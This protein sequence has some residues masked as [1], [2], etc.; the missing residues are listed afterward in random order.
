MRPAPLALL[1]AAAASVAQLALAPSLA[2]VRPQP[3]GGDPR[4]QIAN[5]DPDEVIS[6]RIASGF[7]LTIQL[8]T[9]ERV[10][11]ISVGDGSG[12][13]VQATKRGDTVFV[14]ST[15]SAG[16][17]NLTILTDSRRYLFTLHPVSGEDASAPLVL[18]FVYPQPLAA[19]AARVA[20]PAQPFQYRV[21]GARSLWPTSMYDDG[22]KTFIE[23]PQDASQPA[24]YR[25]DAQGRQMLVNGL[26]VNRTYVIEGFAKAYLFKLGRDEARAVRLVPKAKR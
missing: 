7:V 18:R 2:E 14:R 8:S 24:V 20:V 6:L 12:W 5:Y 1:L 22:Q 13:Q 16:A 25:I 15:G 23:W 3:T 21:R 4:V 10:E 11:A 9:D 26:M 17:T 19:N